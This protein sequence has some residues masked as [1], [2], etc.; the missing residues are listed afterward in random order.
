VEVDDR[1]R[2]DDEVQLV[3]AE[4]ARELRVTREVDLGGYSS[5]A[6]CVDRLLRFT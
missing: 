4:V 3:V 1:I 2:G 5:L 6:A